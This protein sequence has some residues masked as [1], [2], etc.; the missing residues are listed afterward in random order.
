VSIVAIG[1]A[2][3]ATLPVVASGRTSGSVATTAQVLKAVAAAPGITTV[4]SNLAV[5]LQDMEGDRNDTLIDSKGCLPGPETVQLPGCVFGDPKGKHTLIL[6]GDSHASMWLGAF[7]AIGKRIHWKVILL[8][9][10]GCGA[11]YISFWDVFRQV[12]PFKECDEWHLYAISR[13]NRA[14]ADVV[15]V[16]VTSEFLSS[17]TAQANQVLP[18]HTQW[19]A[20]LEKTLNLIVTPGTRKVVLGDIP[21]L[22]QSAPECLAANQNNVQACSTP[23]STAVQKDHMQVEQTAARATKARYVNVVPWFC[24]ATCTPIV[25]NMVVYSD[26]LHAGRTYTNYLSGALQTALKPVLT[27][28]AKIAGSSATSASP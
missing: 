5:P 6:Y 15:V 26:L 18:A 3:V 10:P 8:A 19:A 17:M 27:P 2:C 14:K 13:I 4:P 1:L 21:Y 24:S 23:T 12:F 9:K 28:K 11:P 20:G 7:D 22:T 25:G 16:V